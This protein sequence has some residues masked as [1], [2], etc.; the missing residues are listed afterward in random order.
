MPASAIGLPSGPR[1]CDVNSEDKGEGLGMA[2][3]PF[4]SCF[5][6]SSRSPDGFLCGRLSVFRPPLPLAQCP[7]RCRS[8]RPPYP[9]RPFRLPPLPARLIYLHYNLLLPVRLPA[10]LTPAVPALPAFLPLLCGHTHF[11]SL[12]V[13]TL[14]VCL[15]LLPVYLCQLT[16]SGYISGLLS[17]LPVHLC[18]LSSGY[19]SGLLPPSLLVK[20]IVRY[21]Y[22]PPF[23][24]SVSAFVLK[25]STTR[26]TTTAARYRSKGCAGW[27]GQLA[28]T[29]PSSPCLCQND[30]TQIGPA[31]TYVCFARAPESYPPPRCSAASYGR[32]GTAGSKTK[33]GQ[34][35]AR[36]ESLCG[37][38]FVLLIPRPQTLTPRGARPL[39]RPGAGSS[40]EAGSGGLARKS[41]GR[42][43]RPR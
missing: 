40:L 14:P 36:R 35:I 2:P 24:T 7:N 1:Q 23:L 30:A 21:L 16:T 3:E 27:R 26:A 11:A 17:L 4:V 25:R 43:G 10:G 39:W 42:S 22:P 9:A 38:R 29:V 37:R 20:Q 32:A 31:S 8:T 28:V 18:Q 33:H 41:A 12:H 6:S 34:N 19:T 5:N 15:P 13:D